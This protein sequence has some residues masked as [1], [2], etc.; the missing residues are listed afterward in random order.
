MYI[1][2]YIYKCK[3]DLADNLSSNAKLFPDD[4]S[5]FSVVHNANTTVKEL[6]NDLVK[7]SSWAYQRKNEL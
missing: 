4:T 7:I 2:I 5:L 3:N 1:Y 6:N